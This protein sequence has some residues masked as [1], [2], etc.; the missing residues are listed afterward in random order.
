MKKKTTLNY[1]K[2]LFYLKTYISKFDLQ[3]NYKFNSCVVDPI[4]G[5]Y[6]S[7]N[8]HLYQLNHN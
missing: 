4:I 7:I 8:K 6:N 1:F 5:I 2:F 3:P